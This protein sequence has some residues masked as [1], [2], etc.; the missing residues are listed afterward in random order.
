VLAFLEDESSLF[1]STAD[2]AKKNLLIHFPCSG[3]TESGLGKLFPPFTKPPLALPG[4]V[5]TEN[6]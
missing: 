3:E 1:L 6:S 4:L 5:Q 2:A